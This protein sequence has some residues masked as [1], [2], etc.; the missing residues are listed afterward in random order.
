MTYFRLLQCLIVSALVLSPQPGITDITPIDY[1]PPP[2]GGGISPKS[3]HPAIRLDDQEVIVRLKPYTYTV[4]AIFHLF[5]TGETS[6]EWIGFPKN[7]TGRSPGPLGRVDD[8]IRFEGSVNGQTIA[9]T[10]ERDLIKGARATQVGI[11]S[12]GKNHDGWL[13]G[14]GAFPGHAK[15]TIRVR[16]ETRYG[17]CGMG[18]SKAVYIYGT[19]GYWKDRIGKAVF[20]IDSTQKGGLDRADA[21]FSGHETKK[22]GIRRRLISKNIAKCEIR[23]FEPNPHGSMTFTFTNRRP[24]RDGDL[25][26]LMHASM[27]G[28]LEQVRAL[29]KKGVDVNAQKSFGGTPLMRA[30]W[31]GHLEVAKLLVEKGADVNAKNKRGETA[32]T[33]AL[34][35]AWLGRGQ[36]ET[37]KFLK[38]QGAKPT[39]LA[40]A[41]FVGDV[42]A[43]KRFTA[44]GVTVNEK[45]TLNEPSPLTAAAMGGQAEVVAFLLDKGLKIDARN[46]QGET[47]LMAAAR[48]GRAEVIKLLLDRG[49]D[50]NARDA[51]RGTAL[52]SAV[53]LRGHL[54]AARVLL[55]RG[56]DIEA[57]DTPANRTILMH[58]AQSGDLGVVKL[59]LERGAQVNARDVHGDTALSLARGKDIEEIEKVLKAHGAK[60]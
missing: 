33:Q 3:P 50:V 12:R 39:T 47:A 31:G 28:R 58:A 56:A 26:E 7:S 21:R 5:N 52:N 53:S 60:K 8:F 11:L 6:T 22:Y 37:A 49:A 14:E 30:A 34:S 24:G 4:D 48:A 19:G 27:N 40:V 54:E 2:T 23:N 41:A 29:L 32:L 43:V 16:Y 9:F 17:N 51:Q 36:L 42:D 18:C 45:G 55:E 44:D 57:R 13:V 1:S 38:E 25:D 15:T 59:L 20:I 46:K 35:N 10:E